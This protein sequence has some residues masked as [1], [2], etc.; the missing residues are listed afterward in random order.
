LQLV[1]SMLRVLLEEDGLTECVRLRRVYCGGEVLSKELQERFFASLPGV[2]LH[3]LYGPTEV[4]IDATHWQCQAG[5]N[6]GAVPIGKPLTKMQVY[7]LDQQLQLVPVSVAGEIYIGG[8]G[9]ARGYQGRAELTAERFIPHPYSREMGARLYRSGDVGR[10]LETGVL[11]YLGRVDDQ[12][13][14][15]GCR[16]ELG[17]VET[18]LRSHEEIAE[19]VVLL[20]E[21]RLGNQQLVAYIVAREADAALSSNRLR[22]YL[23]RHLPDYMIPASFVPLQRMPRTLNGKIDRHALPPPSSVSTEHEEHIGLRTETENVLAQIWSELLG[24]DHV[25][26]HDNFF[27]IG[28]QSLLATRAITRINK[29]FNIKLPLRTLFETPSLTEFARRVESYEN[30]GSQP[31]AIERIPRDQELACS[32]AQQRLW[33]IEQLTPNSHHYNLSG[34]VRLTGD[35]DVDVLERSFNEII[36]RH[37]TLRTT[38]AMGEKQPIQ[39]INPEFRLTIR[40]LDLR[41]ISESNQ[42]EEIRRIAIEESR[43]PFDLT[44]LPLFR[45]TLMRLSKDDH[46]LLMT[47]HHI[48]SDGWSTDV[49]VKELAA[50]NTSYRIEQPS[51]L[52]EL[53]IQYADFAQWQREW[54]KGDVLDAQLEYWQRQLAGA[55][56]LLELSAANSRPT[57]QSY[58]G[59]RHELKLSQGLLESLREFSRQEG[60]TLFMTLL[61]VFQLLLH[62]DTGRDDIVVGTDVANRNRGEVE[63]LIGFFV[64]Q[65]V[66]RTNV[67]GNPTLRELLGRVRD[68][69]LGAYAHQDVPFDRVVDAVKPERNLQYPPLFQIK[70][71]HQDTSGLYFDLPGMRMTLLDIEVENIEMDLI[72]ILM[73]SKDKLTGWLNYNADLFHPAAIAEMGR[74]FEILLEGV[75]ERPETSCQELR[76]LITVSDREYK[77]AAEQKL[78]KSNLKKL[79]N[80]KPKAI[81]VSKEP[82][83]KAALLTPDKTL[84]LVITSN[85]SDVDL[86]IWAETNRESIE[87]KLLEHGA[88]LFRGFKVDSPLKFERFAQVFCQKLFTENGEHP[89]TVVSGSVYTP[90]FYPADKQILWHNENSFNHQWPL[91]I[92]FGCMVAAQQGGETPVVDARR[93]YDLVKPEVRDNFTEKGIMYVRRYGKGLGLDWPTVFRTSD[94]AEVTA[95]C[96]DEMIECSWDG[97]YLTTRAIRPAVMKHPKTGEMSWF[98]QAQHWHPA[99]LDESTRVAMRSLFKEE[100]LPRNCYY[101][102]GSLIAD[103]D[104]L[105]VLETYRRLE[106]SFSWIKGDVLMIDNVLAAHG[107]NPFVGE[108]A[109]MV[110][111]GEMCTYGD[112]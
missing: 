93:V 40:Q 112:S 2:E 103:S 22:A 11:E 4:S 108:R 61:A 54:F 45:V 31:P 48:I 85:S 68:V 36:R 1:P 34:A 10:Y 111:M 71:I 76:E 8:A 6:G 78:A 28:G 100:D 98:N 101:G 16:I 109:H 63:G 29:A 23:S 13:K 87:T 20:R 92:W 3:N 81:G 9:L 18:T 53:P 35:L 19:A 30:A 66:L 41:E 102:D 73:E 106:S 24:I 37:E 49:M 83:V 21:D 26:I 56:P 25:S 7:V 32:F 84:P 77:I 70:I 80:I 72:L 44:Q 5:A 74:H 88:I 15:R 67:G 55:P 33:F 14:V 89:R 104:M 12:V 97:P 57:V 64:N 94:R 46:V 27:E 39:I 107:R 43:R 75:A 105:S 17:E 91:K 50:L 99:C 38:F 69:A 96:R 47:M 60:V 90:V 59:A 58:R 52:P 79:K 65:L 86:N 62:L 95:R 110:A 42:T 82:P 51:P